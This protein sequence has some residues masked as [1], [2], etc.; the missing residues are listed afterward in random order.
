MG[1]SVLFSDIVTF[2]VIA[3]RCEPQQI[4]QLLN[5]MYTRFDNATENNGVY[6]VSLSQPDEKLH[7][8]VCN[9]LLID[10]ILPC[11]RGCVEKWETGTRARSAAHICLRNTVDWTASARCI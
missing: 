11:L 7:P 8:D 9:L 10:A 6:K 5:E 3:S 4:V 1:L 2:T